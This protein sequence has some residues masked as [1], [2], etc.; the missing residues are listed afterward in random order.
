MQISFW[1]LKFT[2][3]YWNILIFYIVF[4]KNLLSQKSI[5]YEKSR[6][7]LMWKNMSTIFF[8]LKLNNLWLLL[9][10]SF[11]GP[12]ELYSFSKMAKNLDSWPLDMPQKSEHWASLKLNT[13]PV[14]TVQVQIQKFAILEFS[15]T[16]GHFDS[17]WI[18]CL[19]LS[20]EFLIKFCDNF[21]FVWFRPQ[22][23]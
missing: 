17:V 20:K 14:P 22:M 15:L 8:A 5:R 13:C 9:Y 3:F 11:L 1:F 21:I 10:H 6:Y 7:L 4:W 2:K 16:Q 12:L 19:T 18:K 23:K